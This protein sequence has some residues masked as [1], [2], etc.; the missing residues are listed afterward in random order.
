MY[1]S[2]K[3]SIDVYKNVSYVGFV[4]LFFGIIISLYG[5]SFLLAQNNLEKNGVSVKGT[6][7]D[8]Q[9]KTIY[10]SPWVVFK[11]LE[12]QEIKFLSQLEVNVDLFHY[13]VGQ[14]VDVVYH[15][16]H[17]KQAKIDAFWESNFEQLFL[18]L[19]GLF[20]LLFGYFMQK[21][22]KKKAANYS[23]N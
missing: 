11:T 19:F 15:K 9:E 22:F 8:I 23:T 12:G 7:F 20:L 17:P 14:E 6:V 1:K 5:F 2:K 13:V 18:S 10:R 16:D 4:I 3:Q 21:Y